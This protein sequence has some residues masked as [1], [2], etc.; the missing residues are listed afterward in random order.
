MLTFMPSNALLE[1]ANGS[2]VGYNDVYLRSFGWV[3]CRHVKLHLFEQIADVF[4]RKI[5]N[6]YNPRN[7]RVIILDSGKIISI[8]SNKK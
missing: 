6:I 4:T 7:R 1:V 3:L 8:I 5:Y 2:I